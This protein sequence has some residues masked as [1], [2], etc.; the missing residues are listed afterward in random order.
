MLSSGRQSW[1]RRT[2]LGGSGHNRRLKIL[3]IDPERNWGGGEAQVFG[4]LTYLVAKGHRNDLLTHPQG[5]L[6]ARSQRLNIGTRGL[7]VRNDFD[8]R[9]GFRLRRLIREEKYDIVHFH[10]KRA[11]ALSLWLPRGGDTPKYVVTRRMDYPV[12][13]GWYTDLLYNRK[14]D[15]VIAISQ[16]IAELLTDAGV[17]PKRICLIHSGVDA[18]QFEP[19]IDCRKAGSEIMVV[20]SVAVM[21]ERK[22]H[23]YLLE[24][25][26]SLKQRGYRIRYILAGDGSLKNGL[27]AMVEALEL[28]DEVCFVGFI[29][30]VPAFLAGIDIFVMPSLY[31]GL[32]VAV[33]EAMAAG[34]AVVATQVG[35]LAESVVDSVTGFLVPPRDSQG[36][37]HAIAKLVEEKS[38]AH[39]MGQRGAARV[40]EHFSLETMSA[41]NEAY[42]YALLEGTA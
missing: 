24:A 23:R 11:H 19:A 27:E 36:L 32:G 1:K 9:S 13:K 25:A 16:P 22:G 30:D 5:K 21:E 10:T 28:S 3:H 33:L 8:A 34:K 2:T 14:V 15:G 39:E 17:N 40:R 42:Y 6:F 35:G 20:G 18:R 38:L 37:A 26:R 12:T 7:V 4:L 41:N 31:E 29:S